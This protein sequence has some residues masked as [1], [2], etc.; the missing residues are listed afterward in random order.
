MDGFIKDIRQPITDTKEKLFCGMCGARIDTASPSKGHSN[1]IKR[2]KTG[3]LREN[4]EI[5]A[6]IAALQKE[7]SLNENELPVRGNAGTSNFRSIK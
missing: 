7:K 6:K 1:C 3:R 2:F 5:D 4:A